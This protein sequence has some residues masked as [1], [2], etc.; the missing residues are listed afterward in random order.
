MSRVIGGGV[1]VG[2][3]VGLS[4]CIPTGIPPPSQQ[5]PV[6]AGP[7]HY[8]GM[9]AMRI[10]GAILV[11][12]PVTSAICFVVAMVGGAVILFCLFNVRG[13]TLRMGVSVVIGGAVLFVHSL[14][15]LALAVRGG[16]A[17]TAWPRPMTAP[18]CRRR[19]MRCRKARRHRT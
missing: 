8:T 16:A 2:I 1:I 5:M 19:R 13:S 10:E 6:A 14:G 17:A 18:R 9:A 11:Y 7:V 12:D 3:G 15:Y 4:A